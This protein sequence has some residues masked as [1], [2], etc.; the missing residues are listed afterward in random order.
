MF[1]IKNNVSDRGFCL[2]LQ[3]KSPQLGPIYSSYYLNNNNSIQ[4][5]FIYVLTQQPNGQLQSKH[6]WKKRRNTHK[7]ENK[8]IYNIWVMIIE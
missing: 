3:V 2:R 8:A 1:L 7:V 6:E 5:L 4:F